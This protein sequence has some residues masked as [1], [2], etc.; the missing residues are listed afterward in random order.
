MCCS[1]VPEIEGVFDPSST[2]NIIFNLDTNLKYFI[3]KKS[4]EIYSSNSWLVHY[5][6]KS[7]SD[8]TILENIKTDF[9]NVVRIYKPLTYIF[10]L[11]LVLL[12]NYWVL[13]SVKVQLSNPYSSI[14]AWVWMPFF[15]GGFAMLALR[16]WVVLV[17]LTC[18]SPR[19]R[20]GH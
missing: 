11:L 13:D 3:F 16:T 1:L 7:L 6:L 14:L 10:L 15:V 19:A 8:L 9:K 17:A 5:H 18:F 20:P 12:S 2:L 4:H